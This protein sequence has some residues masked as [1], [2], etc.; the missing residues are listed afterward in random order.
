[1]PNE[2]FSIPIKVQEVPTIDEYRR[3]KITSPINL[4]VELIKSTYFLENTSDEDLDRV[5]HKALEQFIRA[6][7][8]NVLETPITIKE[9]KETT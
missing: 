4:S 6:E 3:Y 7:V 5:Y 1:M 2:K 8:L 9:L